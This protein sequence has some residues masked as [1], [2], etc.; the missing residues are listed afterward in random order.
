MKRYDYKTSSYIAYC[1]AKDFQ[2]VAEAL[3]EEEDFKLIPMV[4]NASF[5]CELCLKAIIIWQEKTEEPL[6]KHKLSELLEM[7]DINDRDIIVKSADIFD[8][9]TFIAESDNAFV[10]WR[11]IHEN[12]GFKMISICDLFRFADALK[13]FYESKHNLKEVIE[14][15]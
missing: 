4:V 5:A 6:R 9:T 13:S 7:I 10:E 8:W 14:D 1:K 11:Y 12:D 15:E 3:S 2:T